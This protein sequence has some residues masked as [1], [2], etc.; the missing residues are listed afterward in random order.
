MGSRRDG[1]EN[2]ANSRYFPTLFAIAGLA[3]E[4]AAA[5]S[6]RAQFMSGPYPVIIVPPP[7]PESMVVPK[8]IQRRSPPAKPAEAPLPNA[9][10]DQSKCYHG[11]E[12]VCR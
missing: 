12:N 8:P 2:V 5:T 1:V 3:L 11:Q 7:S 4:T 10:I 9:G 6:A